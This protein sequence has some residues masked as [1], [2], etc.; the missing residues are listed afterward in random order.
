MNEIEK[1]KKS[2]K[3]DITEG[4][5]E[6]LPQIFEDGKINFDKL[7]SLLSD[8]IIEKEDDRFY[9]NWAGKD[10]IFKLIQ[11]PAYGTLKPDK[12]QS[13]DFDNTEN[14]VIVGENL[15]TLKLLLKRY[16]SQIKMIYIDPPYNTG[17][18]FIYRDNFREPLR[19]YLEK[20]GQIDSEGSKLTTN[21]EAS[22]RY[23]S[24]WLNFMYPRLFLAKNLLK[25]DG[26]IFVSIDDHEVH[27]LRKIM[28]EIFG[29]ENFLTSIIWHKVYSPRMDTVSFSESHDYVL[30]YGKTEKSLPNMEAYQQIKERFKFY[31]DKKQKNYRRRSLRKEGK[32][33]LRTDAPNSFFPL[34][35]PDGAKVYPIK[36]NGVEGCWRWSRETYEKELKEDNVEWIKTE[37]KWEVYVKQYYEG[38]TFKPPQT[39]WSYLEVGHTH[40]ANDELRHLFGTRIFDN[41]KPT[42]LIKKMLKLTTSNQ[43]DDIILDFFAGS[44]TTGHAVMDLNKEDEGNRKFI[45]VNL[46][47][48]V[49]D[50]EIRKDYPTVADICL[51]RLRRIS[52]RFRKEEQEKLIKSNKDFGFKVFRLE[53][54]NFNLKD[55][56]NIAGEKN[57]EELRKKY[58]EWLG[59]WINEPL[60]KGWRPI[61][62]VYEMILKEGLDLN[63]KIREIRIKDNSFYHVMDDKQGY[64]FF[65]SLDERISKETIEEIRTATYKEKKFVFLDKALNDNDKINLKVFV[66]LRVI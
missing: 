49:Q 51:E 7:K 57:A 10:K 59:L 62:V 64:E 29:E 12:E 40:E 43:E 61:D 41:P 21:T 18:D 34:I 65:M 38:I 53:K 14:I 54:S 39:I 31:D 5:K 22:G 52:K 45:L 47:E 55:E 15:E 4:L 16:F 46:D 26:V 8:E 37:D 28:D 50:E 63:S 36:P 17:R 13:V 48:K 66:D 2:V 44:G 1:V 11:A 60:V 24:D 58:L 30:C 3:I 56:F 20:T 33:S 32:H 23:H 6:K 42:K 19:D 9:F 25:E 35:A 27:N